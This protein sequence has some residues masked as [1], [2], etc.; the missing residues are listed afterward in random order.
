ML[1]IRLQHNWQQAAGTGLAG[2]VREYYNLFHF[3]EPED[4]VV[5]G[6][7]VQV[8]KDACIISRPMEVRGFFFGKDTTMNWMH[9]HVSI[10][11]LLKKYQLPVGQVF[12]PSNPGFIGD[13]F[14][15]MRLEFCS[16]EPYREQ[17]L[18]GYTNELLIKLSRSIQQDRMA[19]M[20]NS[21]EGRK[22]QDLRWQIQTHPEQTWTVEEMAKMV[23]LSPSRLHTVYKMMFGCTPGKEIIYARVDRAKSMLLLD[24]SA[25][26]PV[27]AERLGYNSQYHFI[28]Q[29]KAVTGMTPGAYRQE[30]Q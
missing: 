20:L 4:V 26:L 14:R 16:D 15:K 12:Y 25:T 22:L 28:R 24:E 2:P 30:N 29:F 17:L 21:P 8:R 27:V 1:I 11:P 5:R 19:P 9:N 23:S 6:E 18:D 3:L 10:A 7:A 13:L